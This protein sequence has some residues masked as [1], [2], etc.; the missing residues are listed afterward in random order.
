MSTTSNI[1]YISQLYWKKI[2]EGTTTFSTITLESR[3]TDIIIL[4]KADVVDKVI[5]E[6]EYKTYIGEKYTA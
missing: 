3:R 5:T 4:A 6:A 1:S 2:K